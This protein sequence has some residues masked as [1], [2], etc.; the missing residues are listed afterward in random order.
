MQRRQAVPR[1]AGADMMRIVVGK[2]EYQQIEP[3]QRSLSRFEYVF[4]YS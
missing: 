2:I 4:S 3:R 1:H